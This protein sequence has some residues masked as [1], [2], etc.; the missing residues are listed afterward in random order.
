M[1]NKE[2]LE[3]KETEVNTEGSEN[4]EKEEN[5]FKSERVDNLQEKMN[6]MDV[7]KRKKIFK[8]VVIG[9]VVFI[10]LKLCVGIGCSRMKISQNEEQQVKDSIAKEDSLEKIANQILD[11]E[12][13]PRGHKKDTSVDKVLDEL[14][15]EDRAQSAKDSA[16]A[17]SKRGEK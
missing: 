12:F 4:T 1:D 9:V 14:V 6:E 5:T 13:Q 7:E 10:V 15:E 8:R 2:D 16:I 3:G 11:Y 17:K